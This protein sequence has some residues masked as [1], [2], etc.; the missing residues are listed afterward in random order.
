MELMM[1]RL[2]NFSGIKE[3]PDN[4]EVVPEHGSNG[5]NNS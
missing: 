1:K 2:L 5:G 4:M 3:K